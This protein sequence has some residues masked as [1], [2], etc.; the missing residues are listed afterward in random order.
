MSTM[1]PG[2]KFQPYY[3]VR[4]TIH[5]IDFSLTVQ[6]ITIYSSIYAVYES[7]KISFFTDQQLMSKEELYGQKECKLTLTHVFED[8]KQGEPFEWNLQ[9]VDFKEKT[10]SLVQNEKQESLHPFRTLVTMLAIPLEP[11]KVMNK[12]VNL[13]VPEDK[14]KIPFDICN[15]I[16][17]K[18]AS[19]V[20]KEIKPS[21]KNTNIIRQTII[22]PM[23]FTEAF[24]GIEKEYGIFEGPCFFQCRNDENTF[25]MWDLSKQIEEPELYTVY[26]LSEGG[27]TTMDEDSYKDSGTG[28]VFYTTGK[29]DI[30]H[31]AM[32]KT[33]KESYNHVYMRKPSDKLFEVVKTTMQDIFDKTTAK[34]GG[35]LFVGDGVKEKTNFHRGAG[36]NEMYTKSDLAKKLMD[37]SSINFNLTRNLNIKNCIRVGVPITVNF[38]S[39][40]QVEY[41]G[42]YIVKAQIFSLTQM[43]A[44]HIANCQI[45]A[46]RANVLTTS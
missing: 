26:V 43:N 22:P 45:H 19:N 38:E 18:F 27:K 2:D 29:I 7:L 12:P 9:I 13:I 33:I 25:S 15:D 20:K 16:I 6:N 44:H 30:K 31:N 42:K 46:F 17:S 40:G 34:D 41:S 35:K 24:D 37:G 8:A 14:P 21:G 10:E 4:F 32:M 5:D 1:V 23:T 28:D 39:T 36:S 11:F 3:D